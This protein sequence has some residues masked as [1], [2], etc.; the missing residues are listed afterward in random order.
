MRWRRLQFQIWWL[1]AAVA[2]AAC[3][4]AVFR[5]RTASEAGLAI[6]L[7]CVAVLTFSRYF[8]ELRRRDARKL[9]TN[10]S[11]PVRLF[12]ASAAIATLILGLSDLAFLAAYYSMMA[13]HD[14]REHVSDRAPGEV[15]YV[16]SDA[17]VVGAVLAIMVASLLRRTLWFPGQTPACGDRGC[18][19][20]SGPCASRRSS[21]QSSDS[22]N[23]TS[24]TESARL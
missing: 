18:C 21:G 8:E 23:S 16:S 17:T 7:G 11:Q 2:V 9:A 10:P 19:F 14:E 1:L 13:V 24:E 12:L 4:C 20:G 15:L 5:I 6:V 22:G 3:A